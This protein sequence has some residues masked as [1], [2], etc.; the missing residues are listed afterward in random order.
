MIKAPILEVFRGAGK[1]PCCTESTRPR[2][3]RVALRRGVVASV[4]RVVIVVMLVV[5]MM[6]MTIVRAIRQRPM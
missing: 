4:T 3:A 2:G 6:V 5:M 1:G